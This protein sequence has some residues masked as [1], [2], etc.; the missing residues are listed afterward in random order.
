LRRHFAK[1]AVM[2]NQPTKPFGFTKAV[3]IHAVAV[4]TALASAS[5]GT[6]ISASGKTTVVPEPP[7]YEAGRGLITL[8]GPSGMFINPTSA[9]LPK[10]AYTVQ[11]C[12]FFPKDS[13]AIVGHGMLASYGITDWLELGGI[14][15]L[16]D[17]NEPVNEEFIVGGPMIRIRLLRDQEWWPQLSIGAYSKWGTNFLNQVTVFAAAYKRIPID[18]DGFFKSIGFHAGVRESWFDDDQVKDDSFNAYWGAELQLPYRVYLVGELGTKGNTPGGRDKRNPY[19]FGV[20]WR[21]GGINL[22]VAGIQAGTQNSIGIYSG[23][24]FSK[25]F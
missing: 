3:L 7:P 24:A 4:G 22:S 18:E 1:G 6:E 8:Q 2:S 14:A 19:A 17:L 5:A 20:Q 10:G 23:V 13:G 21:L 15:N 25:G 11:Y 9:T 16:V 12:I